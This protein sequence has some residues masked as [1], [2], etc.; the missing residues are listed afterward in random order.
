MERKLI[1]VPQLRLKAEGEE[2]AGE[3]G[4]IT[5]YASVF[6]NV[7]SMNERVMPGA[8]KNTID[9]FLSYGFIA[10]GHD[11]MSL[12]VATPMKAEEDETGLLFTADFHSTAAAQDARTVVK[13]RIDRGKIVGLSIGY[14]VLKDQKGK[15]GVRELI[16]LELHETSIVTL[17]ANDQ[18]MGTEAKSILAAFGRNGMKLDDQTAAVRTAVDEYTRRLRE[19]Q[20]WLL[21]RKEGRVLSDA[22]RKRMEEW[23]KQLRALAKEVDALLAA[24]SPKTDEGKALQREFRRLRYRHEARQSLGGM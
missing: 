7:D 15:D 6:N 9:H 24:T 18:A 23:G 2:G 21:N 1:K 17:G 5:G 19:Q 20:Q 11:W 4:S 22:N 14:E 13:E 3:H 12:P 8:F 10:V 16:E